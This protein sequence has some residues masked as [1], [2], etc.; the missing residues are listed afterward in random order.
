MIRKIYPGLLT[1]LLL[2]S[3]TQEIYQSKWMEPSATS[4]TFRFYHADSKI[5]Y[6]VRNDST[7]LYVSM[8]MAD[9]LT[10]MKVLQTGMRIFLGGSKKKSERN[11]LQFPI[12]VDKYEITATDLN[13]SQYEYDMV[14]G[15]SSKLSSMLPTEGYLKMNGTVTSVFNGQ[16]ADNGTQVTMRLDKDRALVY[17]A[18]IPLKLLG[19]ITGPVALGI[20]TGAFKFPDGDVISQSDITSGQQ[21]T[22]GD[23]AMGR[24]QG[25]DPTGM[26]GPNGMNSPTGSANMGMNQRAIPKTNMM[27]EPIRF[28]ISVELANPVR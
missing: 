10:M 25:M 9:R 15:A 27:E 17:E 7:M 1:L 16:P 18:I 13:P 8:D 4:E 21:L 5:R 3:C 23:R 26:N 14:T 19:E 24:G 6:N 2:S 11:E 12:Y 20:E 28:W 22:A